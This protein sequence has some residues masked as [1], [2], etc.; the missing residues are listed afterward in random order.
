MRSTAICVHAGLLSSPDRRRSP[1]WRIFSI[2]TI[3]VPNN[4]RVRVQPHCVRIKMYMILYEI[5]FIQTCSTR[6][7]KKPSPSSSS[8]V[9]TCIIC[10]TSDG[11]QKRSLVTERRKKNYILEIPDVAKTKNLSTCGD[12]RRWCVAGGER[13]RASLCV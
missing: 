1:R 8:V 9:V 7:I 6:R 2:P 12:G 13:S 5:I 10:I 3:F 4:N 11:G